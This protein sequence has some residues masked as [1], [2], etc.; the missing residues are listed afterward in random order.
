MIAHRRCLPMFLLTVL[1]A[2]ALLLSPGCTPTD[3][4]STHTLPDAPF[5]VTFFDVGQGDAALVSFQSSRGRTY[6]LVD[7]GTE[8]A[9][10]SWLIPALKDMGIAGLDIMVVT[11]M[12]SDHAGGLFPVL[13]NFPVK[14]IVLSGYFY[15]TEE[16]YYFI[17]RMQPYDTT[18]LFPQAGDYLQWGQEVTVEVLNPRE[19]YYTDTDADENNNSLVLEV[20]YGLTSFLFT[21][22]IEEAAEA[23]IARDFA[24]K[25]DLMKVPHHGSNGSSSPVFLAAFQ[26]SSSVISCGKDN[27]YGHP[28]PKAVA[29]LAAYGQVFRT[30]MQGDI[31]AV[32]D[33]RSVWVSAEK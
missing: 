20:T 11:H 29:R 12:D 7:T 19:P 31:N 23:R 17:Q 28:S 5:N 18:P 27:P 1:L 9:A 30:D 24:G 21:G 16:Y 26:P 14:E 15:S 3:T 13:E 25:V 32:S 33:G 6:V 2:A 22:D 4:S 8:Q 10:R